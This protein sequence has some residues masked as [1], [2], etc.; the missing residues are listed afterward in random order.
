M[1]RA[2]AEK[3]R[4]H[5]IDCQGFAY[6]PRDGGR[7]IRTGA[8]RGHAWRGDCHQEGLLEPVFRLMDIR[9]TSNVC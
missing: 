8:W 2:D 3:F 9:V 7:V 4:H 5:W 6:A 1:K